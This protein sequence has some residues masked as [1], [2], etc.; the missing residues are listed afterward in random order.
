MALIY[1]TFNNQD[2]KDYSENGLDGNEI[3]VTYAAADLGYNLVLDDD[4]ERISIESFNGLNSST[5][6]TFYFRIKF[7]ASTGTKYVF[8]KNGQ[9][10]ATWDGT[11]FVFYII[12]ATGTSSVTFAPNTTDYYQ[13]HIRYAHDGIS[14]DMSIYV[15][16]VVADSDSTNGA[17]VGN[18]NIAYIGGDGIF[19][20]DTARFLLNEFKVLDVAVNG[21]Q[22]NSH[23]NNPNGVKI[24]Q[25][26][27]LFELGDILGTNIN[28][29]NKGYA[30]VTYVSGNDVRIQPLNT[31]INVGGVFVRVGNLWDTARQYYN[32]ITDSSIKFYDG[33]SLSSEAFT[34]AKL[35]YSKYIESEISYDSGSVGSN[36]NNTPLINNDFYSINPTA[37]INLTGLVAQSY[38]RRIVL[39][40]RSTTYSITIKNESSSSTST[41]RFDLTADFTLEAGK[42]VELFY[43][44]LKTRWRIIN[45][46]SQNKTSSETSDFTLDRFVKTYI[47]DTTSAD[48]E[49]TLSGSYVVGDTWNIKK[50][51]AS[52]QITFDMT[53]GYEIDWSTTSPTISN[54]LDNMVLQ[55]IGSQQFIIL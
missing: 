29:T 13:I 9:F 53:G 55:Y 10:E 36:L 4:A 12:G 52:N 43:D 24:Y 50:K 19:A 18:S 37:D 20:I 25:S 17:I 27:D 35:A 42:T 3:G 34:D 21:N 45:E 41:N 47:V 46:I 1:Y 16:G 14:N 44:I 22:I 49:I 31:F 28:E 15:D 33:V 40:N 48:V 26:A 32:L 6:A 54:A 23:V 2:S 30:I 8:F 51:V 38:A 39:T 11:D 5:L 7:E